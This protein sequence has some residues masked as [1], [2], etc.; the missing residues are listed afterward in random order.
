[1]NIDPGAM[2]MD[3]LGEFLIHQVLHL[4]IA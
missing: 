1:V 2:L 4:P 3:D